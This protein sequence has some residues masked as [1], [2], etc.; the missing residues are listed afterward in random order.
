LVCFVHLI[1]CLAF[2][3]AASDHAVEL[4]GVLVYPTLQWVYATFSC[5]CIVSIIAAGV[6]NV[7]N[8]AV[9]V[10]IY[11][12]V[13]LLSALADVA[14][15]VTFLVFGHSCQTMP[16]GTPKSPHLMKVV[17]CVMTSGGVVV[18]LIVLMAF[19]VFGMT[20]AARTAGEVRRRLKEELLPYLS[21]SMG[22]L[23]AAHMESRDALQPMMQDSARRPCASELQTSS[24]GSSS[25]RSEHSL[26][27]RAAPP[28]TPLASA[29]VAAPSYANYGTVENSFAPDVDAATMSARRQAPVGQEMERTAAA[30]SGTPRPPPPPPPATAGEAAEAAAPL[31]HRSNASNSS[32]NP[33]KSVIFGPGELPPDRGPARGAGRAEDLAA[34]TPSV[35]QL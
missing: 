15:L 9:H 35:G 17:T 29:R 31:S 23:A 13:L 22:Q 25:G 32:F 7:Y 28:A 27:F 4:G 1:V 10:D 11:Y 26:S 24:Q 3:C 18:C 14:W 12:Y 19:K 30:A 33:F 6:G 5:L 8:I 34:T 16:S 20:T 21:K 2:I